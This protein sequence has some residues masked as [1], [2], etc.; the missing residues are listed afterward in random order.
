MLW[1]IP[2][3]IS[4]KRSGKTIGLSGRKSYD[5]MDHYKLQRCPP[6]A[7]KEQAYLVHPTQI[8]PPDL[9]H[10]FSGRLATDLVARWIDSPCL[11]LGQDLFVPYY[12][13]C[14][15]FDGLSSNIRLR[16]MHRR[17]REVTGTA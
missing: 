7:F 2:E 16:G 8:R 6:Q 9:L 13:A 17:C 5:F 10:Q 4:A 15:C 1:T 11:V 12:M 3:H 14:R